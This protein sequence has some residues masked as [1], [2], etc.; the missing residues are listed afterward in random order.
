VQ[1]AL[2]DDVNADIADNRCNDA[3][4]DGVTHGGVIRSIGNLAKPTHKEIGG[5]RGE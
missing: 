2:P 4:A 5:V 3:Q 1:S